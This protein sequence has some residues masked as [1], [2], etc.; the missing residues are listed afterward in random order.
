[1]QYS[2]T[3][4]DYDYSPIELLNERQ[5]RSKLDALFPSPAHVEQGKQ[6]RKAPKSQ[7]MEHNNSMSKLEQRYT[8]GAP[9]YTI[10]CGSKRNKQARW[11]PAVVTKVFG[12]RSVNVRGVPRGPTW[13]RHID[14]L[15]PRYGVE[16]DADPGEAPRSSMELPESK[17]PRKGE[18]D[19]LDRNET[20]TR[21]RRAGGRLTSPKVH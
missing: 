13:R 14:Q 8:V 4:L 1:M 11:V 10:Y 12:T 15:C 6:A 7:Q 20:N 16:E 17:P 19:A 21:D 5:I 2:R 9:C 18:G 3:P